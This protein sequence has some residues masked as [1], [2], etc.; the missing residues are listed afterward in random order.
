MRI[1]SA[2]ATSNL[3]RADLDVTGLQNDGIGGNITIG[4][5]LYEYKTIDQRVSRERKE[6]SGSEFDRNW[7]IR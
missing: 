4:C 3:P 7:S 5:V 2:P 1:V 6:S